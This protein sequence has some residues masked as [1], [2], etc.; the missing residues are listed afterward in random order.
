METITYKEYLEYLLK[1]SPYKSEQE[2]LKK[3]INRLNKKR[4][5]NYA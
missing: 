3:E 4:S 5:D 2:F 1:M